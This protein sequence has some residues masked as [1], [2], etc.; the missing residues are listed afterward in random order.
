MSK[1]AIAFVLTD[2]HLQKERSPK[3]EVG[4][5]PPFA[6]NKDPTPMCKI[7]DEVNESVLKLLPEGF[8]A[9]EK[10][11]LVCLRAGAE[12]FDRSK[13]EPEWRKV[14][15]AI[16]D[17]NTA[18]RSPDKL[19]KLAKGFFDS[20]GKSG[21]TGRKAA[22]LFFIPIFIPKG[23]SIGYY[24]A[25]LRLYNAEDRYWL[26]ALISGVLAEASQHVPPE[27]G[28]YIEREY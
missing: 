19:Q 17:S 24:E 6:E 16:V 4:D 10:V 5:W 1:E 12:V 27:V 22:P 21:G 25:C 8:P 11:K 18:N 14:W 3:A 2:W 7:A 26:T 28:G 15:G 13:A 20:I 9:A 23:K